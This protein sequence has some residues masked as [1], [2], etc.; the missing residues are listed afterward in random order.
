[1]S[2]KRKF[3]QTIAALGIVITALIGSACG[4]EEVDGDQS[5]AALEDSAQAANRVVVCHKPEADF[6]GGHTIEISFSAVSHHLDHGD[7]LGPC[8]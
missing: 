6:T 7:F 1:M 2:S 8:F 3:T 5:T 4:G